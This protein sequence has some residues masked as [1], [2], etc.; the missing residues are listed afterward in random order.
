MLTD[1]AVRAVDPIVDLA[2]VNAEHVKVHTF[3][4]GAGASA[5]LV[6]RVAEAAEG[7][8]TFVAENDNMNSKVISSLDQAMKAVLKDCKV[9]Y[10]L[11]HVLL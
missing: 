2:R 10:H 7:S 4:V 11:A 8:A 3:G 6:N 1:G 5:E 9:E